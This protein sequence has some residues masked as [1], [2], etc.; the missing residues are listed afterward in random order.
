LIVSDVIRENELQI[1]FLVAHAVETPRPTDRVGA[2]CDSLE[3]FESEISLCCKSLE[4]QGKFR[5]WVFGT[6]S[7]TGSSMRRNARGRKGV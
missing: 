3:K 2:S 6:I 4:T 7:A 5:G 1:W